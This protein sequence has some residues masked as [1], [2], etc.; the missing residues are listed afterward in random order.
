[1]YFD[2][3]QWLRLALSHDPNHI[4]ANFL[5]GVF[6]EQGLSVDVNHEH[7]FKYYEAASKGQH[8]KALTKLGHL[9]Y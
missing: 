3:A 5:L 9:Y 7:A 6:Y 4:E 8:P 2:A 1:M